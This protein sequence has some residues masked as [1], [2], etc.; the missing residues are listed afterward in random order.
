MQKTLE[1]KESLL[2]SLKSKLQEV[3]DEALRADKASAESWTSAQQRHNAIE[4]R[5]RLAEQ[6]RIICYASLTR[7]C[8]AILSRGCDSVLHDKQGLTTCKVFL[9]TFCAAPAHSQDPAA[10]A[11]AGL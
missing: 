1:E 4:E 10:A 5:A 9:P 2:A 7:I 11:A 3:Q 8:C 6:V